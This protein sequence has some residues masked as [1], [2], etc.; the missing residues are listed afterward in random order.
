[1]K[2]TELAAVNN[3]S[4]L[5]QFGFNRDYNIDDTDDFDDAEVIDDILTDSF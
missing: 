1:M 3:G 4:T 2:K 5:L